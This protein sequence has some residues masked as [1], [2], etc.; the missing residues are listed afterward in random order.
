MKFLDYLHPDSIELNLKGRS[1]EEAIYEL[2]SLLHKAKRIT[3]LESV[4]S[5]V[6]LREASIST[7]IGEGVA[8]PHAKVDS[9][10]QPIMAIGVT[11][12]GIDWKSVD[13]RPA[14]LI[15]LIISPQKDAGTQLRLLTSIARLIK[16][17]GVAP[18][19]LN[20]DSPQDLLEFFHEMEEKRI[21]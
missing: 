8:V 1:P 7:G 3:D 17:K 13:E 12:E 14:H 20:T 5:A 6:Q 11:E 15:I 19:L 2:A 4:V 10:S 21:L 16:Q 18:I 9:V